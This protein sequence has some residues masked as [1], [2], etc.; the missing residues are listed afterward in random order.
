MKQLYVLLFSLLLFASPLAKAQS[1]SIHAEE[2]TRYHKYNFKTDAEY[3]RAL[4]RDTEALRATRRTGTKASTQRTGERLGK[5]VFGWHP[6]WQGETWNTY[7]FSNLSTVAYFSYEVNPSTGGYSNLR[8]W[9]TTGLIE[10]A[11][12]A[13]TK[14]VLTVTNFGSANNASIL[15]DATRR[16]TLI[17]TLIS[18]VKARNGDGVNIDFET[19]GSAERA[20]L[21]SFMN[22]LSDRF[23]TE[24]PG[25][26]VS[27]ALPGLYS[28]TNAFDVAAM[29]QVDDFLIMG[30]DYWYAGSS[31]A[32]PVA[33]LAPSSWSYWGP[34][35]NLTKSVDGYLTALPASKLLLAL[36]YY[37]RR[38]ATSTDA[39][40]STAT[41]QNSKV[42]SVSRTYAAAKAEIAA[43]GYTRQWNSQGSVPYYV[44]QEN[45]QWF[46]TFYDDAESLGLKYDLVNTKGLAGIG[47][48]ALGYDNPA[49]NPE[50]NN[51][52]RTKFPPNVLSAGEEIS[53][54]DKNLAYPN[55][56]ARGQ[57]VFVKASAPGTAVSVSLQDAVGRTNKVALAADGSFDT[58]ALAPGL[59]FL[60]VSSPKASATYR[61]VVAD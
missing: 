10:A 52:L 54:K 14:V 42:A 48:W 50:L 3:D 27:I 16:E 30:Y 24:I 58:S 19:V 21:T 13:G 35:L 37:G 46:Q 23:H 1:Q 28:A 7:D 60:T 38:W 45:G 43:N 57:K 32:G 12:A 44:Y 53:T 15:N 39:I 9:E 55:P 33:P 11:H 25:S 17:S 29:T 36:P 22:T 31:T 41:T 2:M 47:I 61:I 51:L 40:G 6:Y 18:V 49:V 4:G 59:Y 34:T 20:A 26:R 5:K 8:S 56:V